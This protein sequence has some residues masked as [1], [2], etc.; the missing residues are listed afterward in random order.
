MFTIVTSNAVAIIPLT[1]A[2]IN[3]AYCGMAIR[4][5]SENI[6][7]N[8]IAV[9]I[10]S[11]MGSLLHLIGWTTWLANYFEANASLFS[12]DKMTCTFAPMAA[13]LFNVLVILI[14]VTVGR[15]DSAFTNT[16]P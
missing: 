11:L 4:S 8:D 16:R 6:S 3:L 15:Y 5:M 14:V 9:V 1:L 7:V 12:V 13:V 10:S 2:M